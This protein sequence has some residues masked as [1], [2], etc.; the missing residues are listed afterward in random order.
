MVY[1]MAAAPI[2]KPGC[3]EFAFCTMSADKNRIVFMARV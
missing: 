1:A 2:G 3:P